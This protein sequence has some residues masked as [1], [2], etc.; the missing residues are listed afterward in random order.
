MQIFKDLL[1]KYKVKINSGL[2]LKAILGSIVLF[3]CGLHLYY[4]LWQAL[5]AYAPA[6]IYANVAIRAAL[7]LSI[8]F[9]LWQAYRNFW[10]HLAVA[11]YLDA[12]HGANDDLYQ[13]SLELYQRDGE[14]PVSLALL[15]AAQLRI[16]QTQY[17]VP[18]SISAHQAFLMAF[19]T[20]GIF[21]YWAFSWA[22]FSLAF[23]Q[24][25]TNQAPEIIYKLR[26]V[27]AWK[28]Q[29]SG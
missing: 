2:A 16:T 14:T 9:V 20:L 7:S 29:P 19:V 17:T 18:K 5:T 25:Y 6:L 26:S 28:H 11:R 10:D 21:A 27:S 13:N 12:R 22:D 15:D 4:L 1:N 8:I 3:V 24:F 23:S